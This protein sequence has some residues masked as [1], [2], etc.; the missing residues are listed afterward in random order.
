[1]AE[2]TLRDD[3]PSH[4]ELRLSG[5]GTAQSQVIEE[6]KTTSPGSENNRN[7]EQNINPGTST[8]HHEC[9][10]RTCLLS[11]KLIGQHHHAFHVKFCC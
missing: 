4:Q 5:E 7:G 10:H 11:T 9:F 3:Q 2:I 8:T 6:N 1:K